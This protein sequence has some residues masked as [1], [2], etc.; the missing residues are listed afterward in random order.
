MNKNRGRNVINIQDLKERLNF[1]SKEKKLS[2]DVATWIQKAFLRWLINSF[3]YVQVVQSNERYLSL[4]KGKIPS[5]FQEN[6]DIQFIYI[7]VEHRE[8][9]ILLDKCSE[10]LESRDKKM[11]HKFPRMTVEQVLQ[12]WEKE[13]HAMVVKE[14]FFKET[15]TKGLEVVFKFENLTVVKFKPDHQELSLEMA[16]ESALMQHCLGE[17]DN[18]RLGQG[19]Y[20]EYY[21]NKIRSKEIELFSLRDSKNMPHATIALYKKKGVYWLEQIK[22]KQNK[23]PIERYVPASVAFFNF[24]DVQYNYYHNDTLGMSVIY[25]DGRTKRI[26]ELE[27]EKSQ[28]LLIAHDVTL[29]HKIKNPSKSTLWLATL[30]SPMEIEYL[31]TTTD[32][33][34]IISLLQKP[35]LMLKIK[36]SMGISSKDLLKGRYD[37]S[38]KGRIFKFIK[39]QVGRIE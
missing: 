20:G 9:R 33:M 38:I 21:I 6:S 17:F 13:H 15:S 34:K 7:E 31:T 25:I 29:I 32:S 11:V 4:V 1:Y 24:L 12:K 26:E 18:D 10:F 30:R 14:K 39:L 27:D 8:I 3:P 22:G 23:S 35:L 36:L 5:W 28:E 19:G 16:R 37:Y 2:I